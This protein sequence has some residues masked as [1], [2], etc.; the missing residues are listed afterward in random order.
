MSTTQHFQLARATLSACVVGVLLIAGLL[1]AAIIAP[2]VGR[3]PSLPPLEPPANLDELDGAVA[4]LIRE[5]FKTGDGRNWDAEAYGELGLV[6]EANQLWQ[7]AFA[8]FHRAV[9][10]SPN[11]KGWRLHLAINAHEI[12]ELAVEKKEIQALV[13]AHPDFAPAL[14]RLGQYL[15][16]SGD[17]VK[18]AEMFD[19]VIELVPSSVEGLVGRADVHLR[20][21]EPD[22]ALPLLQRALEIDPNYKV[23][24]YLLGNAYRDLGRQQEATRHLRRGMGGTV[25]YLP[26]RLSQHM[27]M[28]AVNLKARTT[29]AIEQMVAGETQTAADT[30][31]EALQAEPENVVAMNNLAWSHVQQNRIAEAEQL[32]KRALELAPD[33][34]T[35]H[36]NLANIAVLKKEFHKAL[37]LTDKSIELEPRVAQTHRSRASVLFR[38]GRFEEAYESAAAATRLN[39]GEVG[40]QLQC[41][42]LALRLRNF[43]TAIR[44][45]DRVLEEQPD[46]IEALVGLVRAHWAVGHQDQAREVLARAAAAAPND[47][48]VKALLENV[49][50]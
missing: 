30:F 10:L 34:Y 26:D 33:K 11:D 32:L 49:F 18:S 8:A 41:A 7:D 23:A 12:G 45:F 27:E 15:L 1:F 29:A 2:R 48:R 35:T 19:R 25:R 28:Y 21:S 31:R 14:H 13:A 50:K 22:K 47:Q 44:H 3:E 6:Y 4:N 43:D 5:Q 39:P 9:Q 38:L 36:I 16:S 46:H 20:R 37:R 17:L 24:H 42:D 40:I